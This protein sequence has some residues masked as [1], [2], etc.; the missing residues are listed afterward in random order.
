MT[1]AIILN[2]AFFNGRKDPSKSYYRF[3]MF[4]IDDKKLYTIMQEAAYVEIP[5]GEIPSKEDCSNTF[6]RKAELEF[7]FDQ[8]RDKEG[9]TVYSPRVRAI[10]S[11]KTINLKAI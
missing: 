6:P 7:S 1:Q 10:K 3:D 2:F 8:Y 11:W 4:N 9:R 5:N